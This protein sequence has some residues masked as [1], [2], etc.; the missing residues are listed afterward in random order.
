MSMTDLS[1]ADAPP[2]GN[3]R[4]N[5]LYF[6]IWR[7]HFYAGLYVVPFLVMLSITGFFMMWF[8]A[9]APEYGDRLAVGPAGAAL[10]L[11]DQEAAALNAVPGA[12][13][14]AG[15]TAPYDAMTPALFSVADA[16]GGEQVVALDPYRGTAL[17]IIAEGDTWNA[18]LEEI[19]G[20]LLIGTLGDRLV[21]I[22][23][24]LGLLLI[25]SGAYLWWPRNGAG[26]RDLFLP[27]LRASGRGFWK[28]LHSVTGAWTALLLTFFFITGLAW[29]GVWGEKFVQ[30]WSTFPAEKW[31]NVPL[32][33]ATHASMNHSEKEVPW[34]LEQT[35]LPESGSNA[36]VTGL[37]AG[38]PVT[39]ETVTALARQIGFAGPVPS[40]AACR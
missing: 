4:T 9:I 1:G 24:C 25:A 12:T 30:A 28:S 5:P 16:E 38:V 17:R 35:A 11:A 29:S 13:G 32:S 27:R 14:L 34:A 23:A 26:V 39:L 3:A 8:T 21:E 2:A 33:D 22:A 7:W 36:G 18:F 37:P 15:Y 31:D 40:G 6:A 10:S 19:H 20:T